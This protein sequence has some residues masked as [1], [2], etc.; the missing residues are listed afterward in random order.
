FLPLSSP[1]STPSSPI[2][3][4]LTLF[5]TALTAFVSKHRSAILHSSSFRHKFTQLCSSIG[6]DPLAGPRRGGWWGEVLLMDGRSGID[7][8]YEF[9]VQI[10]DVCVSTRERNSGMI[11]VGDLCGLLNKLRVTSPSLSS[12]SPPLHLLFPSTPFPEFLLPNDLTLHPPPPPSS[13]P[14][15]NELDSDQA[16]IL[17]SA[18]GG[19]KRFGRVT[20]P[21]LLVETGNENGWTGRRAAAALDNMALRDGM[22]CVGWMSRIERWRGEGVLGYE[23]DGVGFVIGFMVGSFT[24]WNSCS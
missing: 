1:T 16:M 4:Q 17:A 10:V 11:Q 14:V 20:V 12:P 7:W 13:A 8:E 22:G 9:G 6:V 21:E 5:R 23:C 18:R 2:H 15:L 19:G 3:A 24:V